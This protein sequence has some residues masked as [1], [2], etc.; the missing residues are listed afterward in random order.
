MLWRMIPAVILAFSFTMPAG[1]ERPY[2]LIIRGGRVV[3]GSGNTPYAADVAIRDGRIAA[4]GSLCPSG[5]CDAKRTLQAEGLIVAPGFIDVHT[6]ADTGILR[7]PTADNFL[8]DGVTSV[9]GG[10]CGSSPRDFESFFSQIRKTGISV[11]LGILIG[12]STVRSAVMGMERREPTADELSRMESLVEKGMRQGAFGLSTGLLYPPGSWAKTDEIV[13]LARVAAKS[14][15]IYATHIRDEE[16]GIFDAITEAIQVG[17]EA[18]LPVQISHFKVVGKRIWG[19]SRRT[20]AMIESGRAA[21]LDLT[22]DVYPYTAASTSLGILLPTWVHEGGSEKYF[23]RLSDPATHARLVQE[24]T[25]QVRNRGFDRLDYVVVADCAW[26]PSLAGKSIAEINRAKGHRENLEAEAETVLDILASGGALAVYHSMDE[27]DVE[28]ILRFEHSMIA[29]DGDIVQF[30]IGRPHPRSYGTNA[31]V[32]ARYVREKKLLPL[33]EAIR[34]MT[35]LP[36]RR[37][38]LV[39]RGL[40]RPTMRADILVFDARTVADLAEY[41]KPHAFSTGFRWVIVNGTVVVEDQKQTGARA[42]QILLG[43]G[44]GE[45]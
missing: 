7:I 23:Q 37:F 9:I 4:I 2:D 32:L 43:P 45:L 31:R 39:D 13:A 25:Q 15:G 17:R 38:R 40:L 28:H 10:N 1:A 16:G 36:A 18:G 27:Q 19:E 33:E 6:H 34:K 26:D 11:N 44:A 22:V 35:S 24:T 8:L 29:S 42:G 30:G 14:G 20:V 5:A 3:D 12:H 41:E 21:G